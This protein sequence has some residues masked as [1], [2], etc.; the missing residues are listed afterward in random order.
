[1]NGPV[2][3]LLEMVRID[4]E[5]GREKRFLTWLAE[6]FREE[7][8]AECRFD[9]Y[10]N[11]IATLPAAGCARRE[12]ILLCAHADTVKPG[13]GIE[14]VVE[15]GRIRSAGETVLGADD[16][17]GILAIWYGVLRARR[18]PPLEIVITREEEV[19]L[20]GA[21]HLDYGSLRS[22]MGFVFDGEDFS[23]IVIGGPSHFLIDVEVKGRAAHAGMEPEKGISAIL[24]VS[25]AIARLPQGKID[26]ET[27]AN[28]GV[29]EGGTVRNAVPERAVVLAECRSLDHG[30]AVDLADTYRRVFEEEARAMGAVAEVRVELAYR[31]V[32][33]PE[34]SS[35]VAL[36]AAAVSALGYEPKPC[37]IRG[38]TDASI[39]N[40]HGIE[41][42]VLGMGAR[43]SHTTD[44]WIAVEDLER[45]ISLAQMLIEKAAEV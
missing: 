39:L 4:S 33:L 27:T 35:A 23:E 12:P 1:M 29:V 32:C 10:G 44:E 43:E 22:R 45:A 9:A 11:L 31:A 3:R 28:V 34:D 41:S 36:A 25:R 6:R 42:V 8:R 18:R 16:K 19:G 30:K 13:V 2:E 14:P 21:K 38:G 7:L 26:P 20:L 40:Q 17:A 24:A 5:S 15:G 37:L